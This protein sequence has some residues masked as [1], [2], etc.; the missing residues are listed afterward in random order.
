V[1]DREVAEL[2]ATLAREGELSNTYIFFTSDNGYH[3]G[4]HRLQ[5]GKM[6]PYTT[7]VNVP[8]IVRGPE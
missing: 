4:E 2:V 6:T 5:A 1:V 7:D 8:L 3:M